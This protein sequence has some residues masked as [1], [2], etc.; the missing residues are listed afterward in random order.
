MIMSLITN[1]ISLSIILL[2]YVSPLYKDQIMSVGFFALSGSVTNWLAIHMLFEKVPFLYG[3]GVIP[4]RF[5]EFKAGIRQ[6]IMGQ[7]FN[8][9][10]IKRFF[11]QDHGPESLN[12]EPVVDK[13]DYHKIFDSLLDVVKQSQLGGMLAMFGGE[14]ALE[15]MRAPFSVKMRSTV[16]EVTATDD[17]QT[18]I[19]QSFLGNNL[20]DQ[21]QGKVE[22]IVQRRLDELTPHMVKTIIQEMIKKHLG[23]LVVWGG[24]F[25]GLI[26]FFMSF[27]N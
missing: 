6:L 27:I 14:A 8:E 23:W 15:P 12:F 22:E 4:N 1:L 24:V 17:F 25:G 5:E 3:S 18:A 2:G 16:L 9:E 26:G 19:K 20:S 21:V 11:E 7:F 10:N 13:L